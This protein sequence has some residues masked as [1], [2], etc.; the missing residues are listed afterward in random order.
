MSAITWALSAILHPLH[1]TKLLLH[2]ALTGCL[3]SDAI[4]SIF[5]AAG[6]MAFVLQ[7][8][9]WTHID[10]LDFE[11]NFIR[12]R[13]NPILRPDRGERMAAVMVVRDAVNIQRWSTDTVSNF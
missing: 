7:A 1:E 8:V 9:V 4:S 3:S 12:F 13:G 2:L 6:T 5:T 10:K 11:G